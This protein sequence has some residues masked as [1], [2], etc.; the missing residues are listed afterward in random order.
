MLVI[1]SPC[2]GSF[3]LPIS[4]QKLINR[5]ELTMTETQVVLND[6]ELALKLDPSGKIITTWTIRNWRLQGN[7][8]YFQVGKRIFYRLSSVLSWMNDKESGRQ[9]PEPAQYGKLRKID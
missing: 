1:C 4:L 9:E 8:P 7:L 2:E 3:L 6:K 5:E